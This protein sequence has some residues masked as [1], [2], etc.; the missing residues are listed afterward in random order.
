MSV[1]E[2]SPVRTG[3]AD[4]LFGKTQQAVLG[5][6]FCHADEAFYLNEIVRRTG[7]GMGAVQRELNRLVE[8]E[9]VTRTPRGNLVLF[10]ANRRSPLFP[11]LRELMVRTSGAADAL[12]DALA[13]LAPR[14]RVAF[15]YGSVARGEEDAGSDV[16]VM[17]V[18][19]VT[20]GEVVGALL[21]TQDVL[22]REVN[23]TVYPV[24][25]FRTRA[26]EGSSFLTTVVSEPKVFLVGGTDELCELAA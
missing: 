9:L 16:D 18:G 20:F 23:P 2:T 26:A 15:V 7:A 24:D 22:G 14:I 17:V 8:A 25:E 12:R 4:A 5:L 10:Q 6:L 11:A 19:D 3:A 21:P 13:P 1:T